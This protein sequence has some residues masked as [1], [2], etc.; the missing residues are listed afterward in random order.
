MT[1]D[2]N[3][4]FSTLSQSTAA[5]VGIF[6]AFI[7]AKIFSNQT[8]F[9]EKSNKI[10]SLEIESKRIIDKASTIDFDW[11]NEQINDAAYR[12]AA[13][14]IAKIESEDIDLHIDEEVNAIYGDSR[15]SLFSDKE[16]IKAKLKEEIIS[17]CEFL[18]E[19]RVKSERRRETKDQLERGELQGVERLAALMVTGIP[20]MAHRDSLLQ[21]SNYLYTPPWDALTKERELVT[22]CH[23]EAKHHA[24]LVNEFLLSAQGNPESPPQI[25]LSL[26][27]VALIFLAGVIYPLTFM[28]SD[29]PPTH[30]LGWATLMASFL[31][32]KG[33]LLTLLTVSFLFIVGM[34][35]R[36]NLNMKYNRDSL[37]NLKTLSDPLNYCDQFIY[38][39]NDE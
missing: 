5:I 23:L 8:S 29:N 20:D 25:T 12:S 38:L 3:W 37:E 34:F 39:K 19:Q 28:P 15:F 30:A 16:E 27:F 11:Y 24:R 14:S 32:I 33:A 22:E 10:K 4:F 9:I 21:F 35:V 2:W 13:N 26:L 18:R 31:S 6:G 36:T 17:H 7:I 1:L